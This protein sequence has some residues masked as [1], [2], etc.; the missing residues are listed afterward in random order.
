MQRLAQPALSLRGIGKKGGSEQARD[1]FGL[2]AEDLHRRA[3]G[4]ENPS[5]EGLMDVC[6]GRFLKKVAELFLALGEPL[7]R[8]TQL[9]ADRSFRLFQ[10]G[11]LLCVESQFHL[12]HGQRR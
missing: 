10:A 6:D 5:I 9:L 4:P 11:H 2:D 8:L 12:I 3:I 7:V 1:L